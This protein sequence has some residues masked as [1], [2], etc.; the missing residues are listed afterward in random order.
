[1]KNAESLNFGAVIYFLQTFPLKYSEVT[2]RINVITVTL[3]TCFLTVY[4]FLW[5]KERNFLSTY[6]LF[7]VVLLGGVCPIF[8]LYLKQKAQASSTWHISTL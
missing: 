5:F 3:Q 2:L 6:T 1:M 4:Q 8:A 7:I